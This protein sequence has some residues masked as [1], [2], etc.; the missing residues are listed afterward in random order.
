MKILTDTGLVAFWNKIKQLVLGNRPYEPTEFSGKGYK[1]LEKNIQTV[2]G[3][4][5]NILTAIMLNQSNTIYEI[6]Y[7]FDLN[8]ETIEMQEGCTLKFEGGS[9]MNGKIVGNNTFIQS[10]IRTIFNNTTCEGTFSN[11]VGYPEWFFIP[12]NV[13]NV[14]YD[15]YSLQC[16]L[17]LFKEVC[18]S[19]EYTTYGSLNL[20]SYCHLYG[21][22]SIT[23]THAAA[24]LKSDGMKN[25]HIENLRFEQTDKI[26][27]FALFYTASYN[28]RIEHCICENIGIINSDGTYRVNSTYSGK[29]EVL[30]NK[31]HSYQYKNDGT[32][33]K[34]NIVNAIFLAFTD[35]IL[36]KSNE[37]ENVFQAITIWGGDGV[38][39]EWYDIDNKKPI[40]GS[41]NGT[42]S[43]NTITN[44]LNSGIFV[45]LSRQFIISN[46]KLENIKAEILDAEFSEDISF[47][48]NKAYYSN[49]C[50]T[51]FGW[52]NNIIFERNDVIPLNNGECFWFYV[53]ACTNGI[54]YSESL[55]TLGKISLL[56]N[57][58]RPI[59]TD[60]YIRMSSIN[61]DI[62]MIGNKL[63]NNYMESLYPN[64][65][66]VAKDNILFYTKKEPN[67]HIGR[68]TSRNIYINN[69][70]YFDETIVPQGII[71]TSFEVG[72]S[73]IIVFKD[74][75]IKA[76]ALNDIFHGYSLNN[77]NVD[78]IFENNI[79]SK[80]IRQYKGMGINFIDGYESDRASVKVKLEY[81]NNY[82]ED[83]LAD[84]YSDFTTPFGQ[85]LTYSMFAKGSLI[86]Y[87]GQ[88][89]NRFL[90]GVSCIKEGY[91]GSTGMWASIYAQNTKK[92]ILGTTTDRP[93]LDSND[94]GFEFYD[95]SLKKKI[96]WNGSSWVNMDGTALS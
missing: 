94:E 91:Y 89:S 58:V 16:A 42:I 48:Q 79:L 24:L 70:Y 52:R 68:I 64:Y 2:G 86:C 53:E 78:I 69:K 8:G 55:D 31:C 25:I 35:N 67:F 9:L 6:R 11:E 3:V 57:N 65:T 56:Y 95:T 14:E 12:Y 74:N 49:T 75:Y 61:G 13:N 4:K 71:I 5:K 62:D 59:N 83:T 76:K 92:N 41:N 84:L 50:L 47:V 96:L 29:V 38:R 30:F 23:N 28:I 82:W 22:G 44:C 43:D 32:E 15:D 88:S 40:F 45:A 34:D 18:I 77:G 73:S 17:N 85:T 46:N 21:G 26:R 93:S 27:S 19:K 66:F 36:V 1:V 90:Y 81:K 37:I 80:D 39:Y 54:Y 51:V 72:K 20:K 60:S 33:I 87:N 10:E 63:T 7:D